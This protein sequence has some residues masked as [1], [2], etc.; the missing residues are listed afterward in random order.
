M[1]MRSSPGPGRPTG[2][3][4]WVECT[5]TFARRPQAGGERLTSK[6]ESDEVRMFYIHGDAYCATSRL[7]Q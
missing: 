2:T 6:V 4:A 5:K 7:S 1:R 3:E